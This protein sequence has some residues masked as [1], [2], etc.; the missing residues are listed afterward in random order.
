MHCWNADTVG[1]LRVEY[2][3]KMQYT[4]E[5]EVVR[6]QEAIDNSCDSREVSK[7]TKRK[8]KLQK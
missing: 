2:L 5:R 3:H 6:M 8:D 1:N 7:T 4:Y